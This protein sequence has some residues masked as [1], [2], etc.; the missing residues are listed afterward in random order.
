MKIVCRSVHLFEDC[1]PIRRVLHSPQDSDTQITVIP[2]LQRYDE[3]RSDT[4]GEAIVFFRQILDISD[5]M[6][7]N[8]VM[9]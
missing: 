1:V 3:S 8:V 5:C 4:I 6:G 7:L 9:P 2:L